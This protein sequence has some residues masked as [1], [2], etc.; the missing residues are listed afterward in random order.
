VSVEAASVSGASE[1]VNLYDTI[2]L[3]RDEST[4]ALLEKLH[5]L[6]M[7]WTSKAARAGSLGEQARGQLELIAR[8]EEAFRDDDAR[9]RYD[10]TIAR[11]KTTDPDGVKVDWLT[12]AWTYYFIHDDGAAA[13]AA[14]KAREEEPNNAMVYVVSAWVKIRQEE[15]K[16]A[17]QDADEAFVLD[18]LGEDTADVHHVRGVVFFLAKDPDRAMQSFERALAKAGEGERSEILVRMAWAQEAKGNW[19][20]AHSYCVRGL[21]TDIDLPSEIKR[22]LNQTEAR[23]LTRLCDFPD[24]DKKS[25][26][27]FEVRKG[28]ISE[29]SI[30]EASRKSLL[31]FISRNISRH[32][33]LQD[34]RDK[35]AAHNKQMAAARAVSGPSGPQPGIPFGGI[36]SAFIALL[37]SFAWAGF[38]V[39]LLGAVGY[40]IYAFT[41][42]S[43]WE[44]ETLRFARAQ[45][46][47]QSAYGSH[48]KLLSQVPQMM[49]V[50]ELEH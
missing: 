35:I 44:A 33:R 39:A 28:E 5:D 50:L 46:D 37:L 47:L 10:L 27:L 49:K 21:S 3:D 15:I 40:C 1:T 4:A 26:H 48:E 11:T 9:D 25:T 23:I 24:D 36:G 30:Q 13:V 7:G 22:F 16:Q 29:S 8:A 2:G 17:R 43:T 32:Q 34:I 14:R 6:K 45:R 38:I 31:D 19:E 42:R 20:D 12:R 18:E 41:R